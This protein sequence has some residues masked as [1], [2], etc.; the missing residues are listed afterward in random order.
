[1]SKKKSYMSKN[2]IISEGFFDSLLKLFKKHPTLKNDKKIKSD[3]K[4]LNKRYSDI[5]KRI[6]DELAS[7]GSKERVTA[8]PLKL[9]DFIK[10]V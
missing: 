3:I 5:E 8:K 2:G 10:G 9:T 1:M 6:N 7:Y 4:S